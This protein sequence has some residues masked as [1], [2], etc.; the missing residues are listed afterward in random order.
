MTRQ[1]DFVSRIGST[2]G[3]PLH[4][5]QQNEAR[6]VRASLDPLQRFRRARLEGLQRRALQR[7]SSVAVHVVES[8]CGQCG[9]DGLLQTFVLAEDDRL[10]LAVL[11]ADLVQKETYSGTSW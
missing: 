7:D 8:Q 10:A 1:L 2:C 3:H 9:R 6:L 4:T 5:E 11:L